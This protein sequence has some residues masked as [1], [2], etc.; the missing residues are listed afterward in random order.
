[1]TPEVRTGGRRGYVNGRAS[2]S[3]TRAIAR[4]TGARVLGACDN[5]V[6]IR[7]K[8]SGPNN[9]HNNTQ[10]TQQHTTHNTHTHTS[11]KFSGDGA[12]T[13]PSKFGLTLEIRF[14]TD[15]DTMTQ[16]VT[17]CFAIVPQKAICT[18]TF[19]V[20]YKFVHVVWHGRSACTACVR[21]AFEWRRANARLCV[22]GRVIGASY[23]TV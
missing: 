19:G 22:W 14:D 4:G 10:H 20:S 6:R 5:V 3:E 1:M 15:R 7:R 13:R 23:K 9:T 12:M 21:R 16:T 17:P 8:S 11:E 2:A 18:K